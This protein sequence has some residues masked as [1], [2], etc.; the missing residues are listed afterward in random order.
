[1]NQ[2]ALPPADLSKLRGILGGAKALMNKVESG[3]YEEGNVHMDTSVTGSQLVEGNGQQQAAA[4][5]RP[6]ATNNVAPQIVNGKAHYKNMS[7]SKMPDNIK[8]AMMKNPMPA[9]SMPSNTFSLDDVSDLIDKPMPQQMSNPQRPAPLQ[10]QRQT[11]QPIQHANDSFTVS[12]TALRGIIKDIVKGELLD[13]MSETFAK[14]LSEQ[15]IKKTINT[16]IKEGKIKT[17][18]PVKG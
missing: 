1:M 17:R 5:P 8:E 9:M 14:Q 16:L 10:E 2:Q 4:Q 13:F 18:K 12:E 7:T 3:N 6:N 11:P 15:T